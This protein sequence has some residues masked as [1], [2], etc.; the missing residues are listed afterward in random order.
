CLLTCGPRLL[1]VLDAIHEML[2][3]P[4]EWHAFFNGHVSGLIGGKG[5]LAA[6][7]PDGMAVDR[8]FAIPGLDIVED[9]HCL[10]ADDGEPPLAIGIEPGSEEVASQSVRKAH[11]QMRKI[12]EVVEQSRPLA[13]HFD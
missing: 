4:G 8:E 2:E 12:A 10:A 7:L 3:L 5:P 6:V 13:A 11:M 1:L 9:G